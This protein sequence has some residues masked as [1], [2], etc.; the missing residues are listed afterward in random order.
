MTIQAEITALEEQLKK[1]WPAPC[2]DMDGSFMNLEPDDSVYEDLR[3]I[4]MLEELTTL[5]Q[6]LS[7]EWIVAC[8]QPFED[9]MG[10]HHGRNI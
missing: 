4:E 8:D 10:D 7:Y 3:R 2:L 6:P 1:D 5:N 9:P